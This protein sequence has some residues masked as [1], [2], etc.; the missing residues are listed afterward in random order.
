MTRKL[1]YAHGT[2]ESPLLGETIGENLRRTVERY[3]DREALVMS[4]ESFRAT[5]RQLWDLVD[6]ASRALLAAGVAKGDRV[7]IWSPNRH[8]WVVAQFAAIRIGAILVN[9]NP[10]YSTRELEY[11]LNQSGISVLFHAAR[12]RTSDY[13]AM[14]DSVAGT[15]PSLRKMV[16]FDQDWKDFLAS[17]ASVPD[18]N[19]SAREAE[20]SFDDAINIQ[21]TSGTTGLPKGATLT[22]HG[23]L[24]N[25]CQYAKLMRYTPDDRVCVPVPFYHC[26][27]MVMGT[28]TVVS[29]GACM[30]VPAEAFDPLLTMQAVQAERCTALYGVPTMFIAQLDHPR[31]KEFDLKSLRTGAVGGSLVPQE[32]MKRML[33]EMH[34][35]ETTIIYGMT[36]TSPM[37]TL[38]TDADSFENRVS[39]VGRAMPHVEIRIADPA[40]GHTVLR[41]ERGEFCA[42][43]YHAMPGYWE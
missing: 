29:A 42:R 19:L 25:A 37:S 30:V 6:Q 18:S 1:A 38:T 16:L 33:T 28:L 7:G 3:P 2:G 26:F 31:F 43:G 41:G 5:Y 39:T 20:L 32:T 9:V 36:E 34:M 12:F 13:V 21:Y 27:G 4:A 14:L 22:H 10:S 35:R 23:I 15:C 40:T 17:G 24:N 11:A 8:E